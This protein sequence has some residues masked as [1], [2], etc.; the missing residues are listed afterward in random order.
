[1]QNNIK[2]IEAEISNF[3]NLTQKK[4]TLNGKSMMIVGPNNVG[5]STV[6]QALFS[7]F[8][9]TYKPLEPITQGEDNGSL[10]VKIG[11]HLEGE[12]VEYT[13]ELYFSREKQKGRLRLLNEEGAV[14]SSPKAAL[15][16][17]IG[18]ISFDIDKFIQLS[19]TPT[20]KHSQ[21]G[22]KRQVEML[23]S[24][25]P[26]EIQ[27]ELAQC[28][29]DRKDIFDQRKELNAEIKLLEGNVSHNYS[30]EELDKYSVYMSEDGVNKKLSDIGEAIENWQRISKKTKEYETDIPN[31]ERSVTFIDHYKHQIAVAQNFIDSVK[32]KKSQEVVTILA[33]INK[34]KASQEEKL[35]VCNTAK[36]ILP[37]T[38]EDL[39]KGKKWL[40]KNPKP[41]TEALLKEQKEIQDHN[42]NCDAVAKIKSNHGVIREKKEQSAKLTERINECVN[43]KKQ[44]FS[45]HPL[46]VN[47]LTFDQ[48]GVYYKDLPFNYESHPTS[49]IIGVGLQIAMAMNPNLKALVIKDGSL[50]DKG[51][52]NRI[53]KMCEDKGFQLIIEM[54]DWNG[55]ELDIHFAEEQV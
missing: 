21:D 15:E 37:K 30:E 22:A 16:A 48:D 47:G 31:M 54:V 11:G 12:E 19:K 6:I 55:S 38:K 27:K 9:D 28:D 39:E 34:F 53:L 5:K 43:R 40:E 42:K 36:E 25:M 44:I 49:T 35:T 1:M 8:L 51:L 32:E 3:K 7:P 41:T 33:N 23:K 13:V 24:F 17:I 29:I 2:I 18:D 4:V 52:Y 50:L 46:P 20:G 14:V 45:E 10:K 26:I